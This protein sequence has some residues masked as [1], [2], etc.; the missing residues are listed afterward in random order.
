MHVEVVALGI[1]GVTDPSLEKLTGPVKYFKL[2]QID[3]PI[4]ALKDAGVT[5]V[6]MAGKVQHAS[7][8]G[9]VMPD[10]RAAKS[11]SF[12]SSRSPSPIKTCASTCP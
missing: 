7:L 11:P 6:V 10:F 2:C 1:Q 5:R 12:P 8:F 4:R 3:K 9:G